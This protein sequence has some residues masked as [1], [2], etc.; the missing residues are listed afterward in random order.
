LATPGRRENGVATYLWC[1][2]PYRYGAAFREQVRALGL[3][4]RPTRPH[5]PWRNAH[6][7]RLIGSIRRE[8]LDHI[9]ILN[10]AHLRRVLGEYARYYNSDRTHLALDK[11]APLGRRVERRGRLTSR[12]CLGDCIA[13]IGANGGEEVFGRDTQGAPTA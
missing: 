2:S 13:D 3:D 9:I 7:E 1:V 4:D 10:A 8:C 6:A 11:D 12:P 5:S